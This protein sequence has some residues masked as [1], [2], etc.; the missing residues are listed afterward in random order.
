[1]KALVLYDS[2]FGNTEKVAQAISTALEEKMESKTLQ[3]K[4]ASLSDLSGVDLLIVGSPTRAFTST[5]DT[6]N[7]LK[8]IPAK[9]L[10]NVKTAAFDTRMTQAMV[11]E[12]GK[13]LAFM[14]NLLG[15]AAEPIAKKLQQ[16]GGNQKIK[17]E[18]FYVTGTEGPLADGELERAAEWAKKAAADL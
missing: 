13:F 16:K 17:P 14:V 5:P 4:Q 7:F 15:Y 2:V 18:G 1:M 12:A 6:K 3:V 9:S 10:A 11:N 8:K